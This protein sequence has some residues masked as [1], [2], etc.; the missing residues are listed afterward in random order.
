MIIGS[1]SNILFTKDFE[2]IVVKNNIKG[3]RIDDYNDEYSLVTGSSGEVWHDFVIKTLDNN[4]YGL[5]NLSYIPGTVGAS[6]I[7]NIGAYGVEMKD[8]FYSL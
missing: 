6:A 4:L 1:G 8:Y 3:F 5:E 2:G 7:Q